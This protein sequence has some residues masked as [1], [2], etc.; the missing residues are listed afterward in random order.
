MELENDAPTPFPT[1][2]LP[3]CVEGGTLKCNGL[4]QIKENVHTYKA[5]IIP[6]KPV[7]V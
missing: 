7:F 2:W 1:Y 5:N 3:A 4:N 6:C